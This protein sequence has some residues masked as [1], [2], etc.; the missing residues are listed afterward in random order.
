MVNLYGL[1]Q[2]FPSTEPLVVKQCMGKES[3]KELKHCPLFNLA[4]D[5]TD[6]VE[7]VG[8]LH[9]DKSITARWQRSLW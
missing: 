7:K 5:Y 3:G 9:R 6:L 1:I 4:V 8:I 2:R